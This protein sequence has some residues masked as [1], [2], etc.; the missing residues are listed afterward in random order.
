M[1][2]ERSSSSNRIRP[3]SKLMEN[4][5]TQR[6]YRLFYLFALLMVILGAVVVVNY[7]NPAIQALG[8]TFAGAGFSLF[9]ST[10]VQSNA[11]EEQSQ[12]IRDIT[13]RTEGV[14]T[15]PED[16]RELGWMAYA[17]R[18]PDNN[19]GKTIDW[20]VCRLRKISLFGDSTCVYTMQTKNISG[21]VVIYSCTF[22]GL[23]GRVVGI[24]AKGKD[25]ER[26]AVVI[27]ETAVSDSDIYFGPGYIV[28]WLADNAFTLAMTGTGEPPETIKDISEI[29]LSAFSRWFSKTEW[30]VDDVFAAHR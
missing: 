20:R 22:V 1:L 30:G 3:I 11:S 23:A 14:N 15:L 24:I 7:V 12:L 29:G 27:F 5:T 10:Y 18:V 21:Q 9:V 6:K 19:A 25:T 13:L 28:D 4:Q 26:T 16:F 17:T 2:T 8:A